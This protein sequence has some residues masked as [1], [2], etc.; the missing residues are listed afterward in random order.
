MG[1]LHEIGGT[2]TLGPPKTSASVRTVHLPPF[3]AALLYLHR[4][5]HGDDQFVFTGTDGGLMRRSNFRNRVW[6]PAVEGAKT[7][8][9]APL[10]PGLHFH[11]LRHT[12]KTW[13]I[14]DGIPEVAQARRLGHRQPGVRDIYSHVSQV[15]VDQ[16]LAGLQRRWERT[17]TTERQNTTESQMGSRSFAPNV[18]PGQQNGPSAMIADEPCDQCV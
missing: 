1:A 5:D 3:L 4:Q 16:L 8:G 11:D 14:E 7:R 15:M 6:I 13:M 2:L 10:S 18:L 9:W 17:I 12:H